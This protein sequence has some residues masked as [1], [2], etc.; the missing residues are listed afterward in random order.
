MTK[1]EPVVLAANAN[2][3]GSITVTV[4]VRGTGGATGFNSLHPM[5]S[6]H[7]IQ[8]IWATDQTGAVVGL[9]DYPAPTGTEATAPIPVLKFILPAGTL[10][11]SLQPHEFCNLHG[12]WQGPQVSVPFSSRAQHWTEL[13][14]SAVASGPGSY[15]AVSSHSFET[16]HEPVVLAADANSDGSITVT[17]VVRGTD[18]A[19]GLSSLHPMNTAHYIQSIWVLDQTGAVVGLID[20]PAPTGTEATAPIPVLKFTLPAGTLVQQLTPYEYCNLHGVWQGP[21]RLHP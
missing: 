5:S 4:V 6:G 10:V 9:I 8:S 20:Y 21:A 3:D 15:H 16:K 1:H 7:Y 17:V 14:S 2:I 18:G 13:T 12:L 11:T 19:T